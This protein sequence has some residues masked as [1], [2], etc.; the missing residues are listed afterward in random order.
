MMEGSYQATDSNAGVVMKFLTGQL[1]MEAGDVR[2]WSV[3]AII[4]ISLLLFW[5]SALGYAYVA[6]DR[7]AAPADDRS[8][9]APRSY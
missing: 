2:I 1:K 5:A 7:R 6:D 3:I 4:I 9:P 8:V